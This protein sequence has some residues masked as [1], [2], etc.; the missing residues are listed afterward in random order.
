MRIE[1][2]A[3]AL[4]AGTAAAILFTLCAVGV[5]LVPDLT[6]AVLG[7]L[8]HTDLRGIARPLTPASFLAGLVAWSVGTAATFGFVAWLSNRLAPTAAHRPG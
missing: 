3:F 7:F 2:R 5:F 6:T 4:A 8:T 1:P